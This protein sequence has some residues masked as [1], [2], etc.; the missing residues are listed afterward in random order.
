MREAFKAGKSADEAA[1]GLTL[2]ERYKAYGM[3][4]A[5]ANVRAIYDEL[6]R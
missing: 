2:P 1:A 6:K 5:A 3:D 4:R